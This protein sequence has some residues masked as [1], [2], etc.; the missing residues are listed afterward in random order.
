MKT[1]EGNIVDIHNQ[2]IF[3]GRIEYN[4][5]IKSIVPDESVISNHFILPGLID[6]HVHIESSMLS[7]YEYSKEAIKHGVVS[8][9]ADPHEIANVCGVEGIEYMIESASKT[10][11]KIYFGAPSCVPATIFETAGASISGQDIEYLFQENKC[12]HLGEMMNFPGVINNDEE[13]I[14]KIEI[15]KKYQRVIDGHAPMLNGKDLEEYINSGISTDHECTS[16][17]EAIEKINKGMKIMMRNSSAS[18]DFDKLISLFA[19][20]SDSLMLCTDDCHP[21]DLIEGYIDNLVRKALEKGYSIFDVYKAA[22][23]NAI[24]HYKL[25]GVGSL[26]QNDKADFIVVNSLEN[27]HILETVIDGESIFVNNTIQFM[28]KDVCGINNFY[29]NNIEL[30]DLKYSPNGNYIHV[31]D[32]QKDS[33][34]TEKLVVN[35]GLQTDNFEGSVKDDILKLVVV[36]R[37]KKSKP[38]IAYIKGFNLKSGAFGSTVAH[39]SHNIIVVGTNDHD[40]FNAIQL[41]QENQ[42]ALVVV[43]NTKHEILPL[44]IGGL[45]LDKEGEE[46]ANLYGKLSSFVLGLGC[47]L[48][49]PFMTLAFT[50]LLVIPELKLSDMGLFDGINFDFIDVD[51]VN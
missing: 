18:K 24:K 50:S 42:G 43:N 3:K 5:C 10:P 37:Y 41:I 21:D 34:L 16:V 29:L 36:N 40:I 7:P 32:L 22:N 48:S 33:L 44:P 28:N 26:K 6:A 20:Y 9:L 49:S 35:I 1:I 25:K 51:N 12:L 45:M 2:K 38:S 46:V 4:T 8:C 27:F 14:N 15:A 19:D 13:I 23:F 11:M 47:N 17:N 39:D 30:V 31:I